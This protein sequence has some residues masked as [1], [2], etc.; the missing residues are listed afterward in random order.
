[1]TEKSMKNNAKKSL[2]YPSTKVTLVK[3]ILALENPKHVD[4]QVLPLSNIFAHYWIV[5]SKNINC[6]QDIGMP[7]ASAMSMRM[8]SMYLGNSTKLITNI[9]PLPLEPHLCERG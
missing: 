4:M 3:W 5:N 7:H 8:Q 2:K 9:Q 6:K 1:M